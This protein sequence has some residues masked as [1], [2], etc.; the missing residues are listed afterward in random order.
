MT[1][2]G[3]GGTGK[4]RLAIEAA[5]AADRR[6]PRRRVARRPR[7]GQRA[8]A[9]HPGDRAT[10]STSGSRQAEP[11]D[12]ARRSGTSRDREVAA[13]PRQLRAPGRRLRRRRAGAR[14][15]GCP[16]LRI[17][18]T[19]RQSLRIPGE[20]V[21]RVPSLPRPGPGGGMRPGRPARDRRRPAV[22]RAR[23]GRSPTFALT[24][25]NA[26]RRRPA[27]PSP[28]RPAAGDR[29]R[30]VAG[31]ASC[32]SRRS[33][34][35]WTIASR[36]LV[37]GSRTALSRQQ[38]L[39]ATLDWSYNLLTEPQRRVLRCLSVFVGGAPLEAAELVCPGDGRRLGRRARHP[40]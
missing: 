36:L 11:L 17:L 8:G 1:L 4:T 24:A 14:S 34:I 7:G 31:R 27:V 38:T 26:A 29:A 2:T 33:P 15:A 21:F 18:A 5:S 3:P 16:D 13:R 23:P 22:R 6:L 28:R 39:R 32:R 12:R 40:R 37:G 9:G 20:V 30:R 10:C 19:S 35:G 25:E